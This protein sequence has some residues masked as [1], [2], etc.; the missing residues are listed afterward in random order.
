MQA[1]AAEAF[2]I[3]REP[4]LIREMYG[5][6]NFGRSC[7]LARR[8]SERGV[9]FVQVYYLSRDDNQPWDTH[10][11]NDNRHRKL[12]ADSD[13][14]T[15][16]LLRDLKQRGLLGETLAIWS[17]AVARTPYGQQPKN[18]QPRL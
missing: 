1:E 6:T 13:R 4:A 2:D 7:L 12:C 8:L 17:G 5:D 18:K 3:N 16:A 15:A 10:Q 11:D 9:R 14:A